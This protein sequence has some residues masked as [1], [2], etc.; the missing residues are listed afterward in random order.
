MVQWTSCSS[1]DKALCGMPDLSCSI[2]AQ[3]NS[4]QCNAQ[5]NSAQCNSVIVH[6][7]IEIWK[8]KLWNF[9]E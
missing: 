5:C 6:S 7:V 9:S 2:N 8:V 1:A 3:C 4:V